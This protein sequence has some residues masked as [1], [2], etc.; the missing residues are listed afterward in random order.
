MAKRETPTDRANKIFKSKW[1]IG[2]NIYLLGLLAVGVYQAYT[3]N[4]HHPIWLMFGVLTIMLFNWSIWME[5]LVQE[6]E[7]MYG[8][9]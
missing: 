7:K 3:G 6:E 9:K 5:T 4:G 8:R 1:M 2:F